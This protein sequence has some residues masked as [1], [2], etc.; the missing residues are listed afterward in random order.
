[1]SDKCFQKIKNFVKIFATAG[2][3]INVKYPPPPL[4]KKKYAF[5]PIKLAA[6]IAKVYDGKWKIKTFPTFSSVLAC[7]QALLSG[8]II[9]GHA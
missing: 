2:I 1:M 8:D 5:V 6:I 4:Q 3:R 9:R 7:E